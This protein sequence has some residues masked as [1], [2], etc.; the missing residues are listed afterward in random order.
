MERLTR[1]PDLCSGWWDTWRPI[2]H[3]HF[4]HFPKTQKHLTRLIWCIH[5]RR[6]NLRGMTFATNRE[7]LHLAAVTVP[8]RSGKRRK[9]TSCEGRVSVLV[10][11]TLRRS[12]CCPQHLLTSSPVAPSRQFEAMR[13]LSVLK[14]DKDTQCCRQ[15]GVTGGWIGR[16]R[17]TF[18]SMLLKKDEIFPQRKKKLVE[19]SSFCSVV[20]HHSQEL[21]SWLKKIKCN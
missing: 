15:V 13:R 16:R 17:T 4:A 1:R 8:T 18:V 9:K 5:T 6:I 20:L 12:H 2:Q 7:I 21:K 14:V 11:E 3:Q 10:Y 19:Q